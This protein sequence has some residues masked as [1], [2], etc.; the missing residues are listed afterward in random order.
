MIAIQ[1]AN[2]VGESA[3]QPNGVLLVEENRIA[4]LGA[5]ADVPIPPNSTVIDAKG[6]YLGPGFV[7]IHVHGG[8][9]YFL[10]QDP[11]AAASH[12]VAHGTTTVLAACYTDLDTAGMLA[13]ISRVKEAMTHDGIGHAIGGLYMEG[14]YLNP[15][16]GA[17]PE[18]NQWKGPIRAED[19][20][21]FVKAAGHLA[22]VWVAAPERE[23]L[24]PFLNKV[25]EINPAAVISVGHS[26][27]T[28]DEITAL[29]SYGIGLQTHCTNATGRRPTAQGTRSC[30]PDEACFLE[31]TMYA[32]V[33]CDSQGIHVHPDMLRL[34]LKIKG[35]DRI[36]LISDSFVSTESNPP[37]L[38]HITDLCFDSNGGLCGS[39]L[40]LN[41]ACRN[42]MH[43]TGCSITDV[44]RMASRNPA[45]VIGMDDEI[46]TLTVGK[47]ANLVLVDGDFQVKAVMLEGR[48][49]SPHHLLGGHIL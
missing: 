4:A 44:F 38:S 37:S 6:A 22:K 15:K 3:I 48:L 49:L 16:Y 21:S 1:N 28:P 31:D 40:T 27:A 14:P 8:G 36:L 45:R 33:I 9:G 10:Y 7:D 35:V 11:L 18:K 24:I 47:K 34:I 26:E 2:L 30:G 13:A 43:H 29:K 20:E 41:T 12:F 5:A 32:E 25:K 39:K 23:G 42:M 46:G 17:Q 19:Y